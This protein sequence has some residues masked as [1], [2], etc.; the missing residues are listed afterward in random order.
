MNRDTL[1]C[2]FIASLP[3]M[4]GYNVLGIGFGILLS[5]QGYA[6][7]WATL[8][9]I[10][11]FA[12]SMQYVGVD[13]LTGGV[14]V[15]SAALMTLMVNARHLFYGV[16]MLE[17]YKDMGWRKPYLIF[18]LTDETYS[19][20]C[21]DPELP[22]TVDRRNFDILL[23]FMNQC[24]WVGGSTIGAL[25]G[26]NLAF[27][28]KGVEFSMTALF[29]VIFVDQ[30]EKAENHLPA[31]WGLVVTVICLLIF[32]SDSFLIPSMVLITVGLLAMQKFLKMGGEKA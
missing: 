25:L 23:T 20:L 16:S 6:F 13:L 19:I 2:A 7:W 12:G 24:Y 5:A 29:V 17:K 4:A 15:I 26:N 28:S 3:V 30:W 22:D 9:S 11:I 31:L 32:G 1:K 8:M 27:N 10:F 14:S 21:S 18:G